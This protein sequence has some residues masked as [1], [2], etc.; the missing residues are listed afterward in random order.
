MNGLGLRRTVSVFGDVLKDIEGFLEEKG[1]WDEK[2]KQIIEDAQN[3][4]DDLFYCIPL[5]E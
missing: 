4:L 1:L 2:H 3:A 5:E